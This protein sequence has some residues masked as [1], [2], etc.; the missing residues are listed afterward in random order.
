MQPLGF[1]LDLLRRYKKS[2]ILLVC[3]LSAGVVTTS[4]LQF[5]SQDSR[6]GGASVRQDE[7]SPSSSGMRLAGGSQLPPNYPA[8]P[9]PVPVP[10][11]QVSPPSTPVFANSAP[12]APPPMAQPQWSNIPSA[13]Q[14]AQPPQPLV[15]PPNYTIVPANT[16]SG[17]AAVGT[18]EYSQSSGGYPIATG[19]RA[20]D[21]FAPGG[22]ICPVVTNGSSTVILDQGSSPGS[23]TVMHDPTPGLDV[24]NM[25]VSRNGLL[26]NPCCDPSSTHG[27]AYRSGP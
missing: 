13:G 17:Y 24:Q 26:G 20:V 16:P 8:P 1:Y 23:S 27:R 5:L 21:S 2:I 18:V 11:P 14:P 6:S 19:R 15:L 7:R 3:G 10:A 25:P 12:S 9:P 4:I 22:G